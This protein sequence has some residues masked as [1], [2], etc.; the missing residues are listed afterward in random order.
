MST[1]GLVHGGGFGAW[2]WERLIPELEARD[3]CAATIDLTTEDQEAGAAHCSA[4]VTDAFGAIDDLVLVGH[5]LA[6]LII[7]LV[8]TERPVRNLVFLHALI[9]LPGRSVVDQ[10]RAEPDMF[11]PEMFAVQRPFWED[12][13]VANRFLFHDCAPE[14]AQDAFRQ[15]RPETGMLG[16]EVTP[17][18]TGRRCRAHT[19][20]ALRTGLRLQVGRVAPPVS[21][22]VLSQWRYRAG[23][24]L[25]CPVHDNWLTCLSAVANQ[26]PRR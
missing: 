1:F 11:I 18:Q 12:F 25:S 8:A 14:V 4:M 23:I 5:S 24:V 17:L 7:P 3:H 2:C 16:R 13:E 22:W 6:G 15:L 9:P 19:S 20:S 26:S 10:L 21:D